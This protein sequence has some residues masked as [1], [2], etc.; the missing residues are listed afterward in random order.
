VSVEAARTFF[1]SQASHVFA[2]AKTHCANWQL[3]HQTTFPHFNQLLGVGGQ[4]G[5]AIT[6]IFQ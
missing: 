4:N 1:L 5:S 2:I 6:Y 3:V